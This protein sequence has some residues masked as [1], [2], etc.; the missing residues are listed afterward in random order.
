MAISEVV[1]PLDD[2][3]HECLNKHAQGPK[4]VATWH[5]SRAAG[6]WVDEMEDLFLQL[7]DWEHLSKYGFDYVVAN[8]VMDYNSEFNPQYQL[9]QDRSLFIFDMVVAIARDHAWFSIHNSTC[10][11]GLEAVILHDHKPTAQRGA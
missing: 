7:C 3:Y 1:A 5:A 10:C 11:P 4:A 6:H 8:S 9:M 2:A